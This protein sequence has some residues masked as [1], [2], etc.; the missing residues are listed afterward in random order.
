LHL[1]ASFKNNKYMRDVTKGFILLSLLGF[2]LEAVPQENRSWFVIIAIIF[3]WLGDMLLVPKGMKFFVAGGISFLV[4]HVFFILSYNETFDI[5]A[6]PAYITIPLIVCFISAA[7]IIFMKLKKFLNKKIIVPMFVYLITNGC[8]NCFAIYR[9]I[10]A[11]TTQP[12][13]NCIG[14]LIAVFGALLFFVSDTS[15]YFVRFNKDSKMKSHF[16]V[17]LTYSLAELLIILGFVI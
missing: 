7:I 14:P 16:L 4:S 2:Y 12:F 11:L 6:I 15:L 5:R 3:S 10:Y 8:M 13:I 9:G 17:M 1:Y